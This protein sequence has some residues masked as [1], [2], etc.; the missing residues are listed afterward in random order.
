MAQLALYID[1]ELAKRLDRAAKVAKLSRSRFV[2]EALRRQL[3]DRLPDA[4]FEVLGSWED[5]RGPAG[6]LRDIRRTPRDRRV[7]VR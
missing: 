1:D 7:R 4:F 5:D 6:I 3:D 2:A